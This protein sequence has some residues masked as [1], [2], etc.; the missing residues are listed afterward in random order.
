MVIILESEL[1]DMSYYGNYTYINHNHI[2]MTWYNYMYI[3]MSISSTIVWKVLYHIDSYCK[4]STKTNKNI[5][6]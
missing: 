2:I 6:V 5:S 1:I 4:I 3:C